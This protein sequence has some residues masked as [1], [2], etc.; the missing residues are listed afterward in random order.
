MLSMALMAFLI[1]LAHAVVL[2]LPTYFVLSKLHLMRWWMSII[3]GFVIGTLPATIEVWRT[4]VSLVGPGTDNVE[5][6]VYLVRNGVLTSAWWCQTILLS[7]ILGIF[8]MLG[9]FSAWLVW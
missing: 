6:G 9:A 1:A 4:M 8:G 5:N 2:G 3:C 7:S